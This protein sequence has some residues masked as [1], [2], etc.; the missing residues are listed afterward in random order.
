M[1]VNIS[2]DLG[3]ITE[4]M[5]LLEGFVGG[6][7]SPKG[8][9]QFVNAMIRTHEAEFDLY[10]DNAFRTDPRSLHHVYEWGALHRGIT[11]K[12]RLWD[13]VAVGNGSNKQL[14]YRFRASKEIVPITNLPGDRRLP[15]HIFHWKAAVMEAGQPLTVRVSPDK[16]IL[17]FPRGLHGTQGRN[18][19]EDMQYSK[20]DVTVLHPGG[21]ESV[22][23]F[24][25]LWESY[26]AGY[27]QRVNAKDIVEPADAYLSSK[28]PEL[29]KKLGGSVALPK[30]G[31]TINIRPKHRMYPQGERL[32]EGMINGRLRAARQ[33]E[34]FAR[35]ED[36]DL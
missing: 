13:F 20:Q 36:S 18:L 34:L 5:Q 17:V 19:N 10:A 15:V 16:G 2:G 26:W 6:M 35:G 9:T 8:M 33:R 30:A 22:G 24:G 14:F 27:G 23:S 1:T 29:I 32:V 4:Y 25:R 21:T 31:I 7:K 3:P 12:D 28:F 11:E